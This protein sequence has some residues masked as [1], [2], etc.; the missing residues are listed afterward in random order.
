MAALGT[1]VDARPD[2]TPASPEIVV[3]EPVA[4][5][6]ASGWMRR[7]WEVL[8]LAVAAIVVALAVQHFVYPA[9]SW[10]R[11]EVTYLWQVDGLSAGKVLMTDGGAPQ[12]FWPWLA[13]HTGSAFFAQ[14]T[15]GWPLLLLAVETVFG[16]PL[17]SLAFGT[18]LAVVGTYALARELTGDRSLAL[19][20]GVFMLASPVVVIQSGTY[21]GYLFSLGL[22]L[23]FGTALLAGLRRPSTGLLLLAGV[24]LG[25]LL[26]TRPLDAILWAAP[27]AGYALVV[28]W[29]RWRKLAGATVTLAVGFLPFVAVT[30]LYNRHI[31]GSL[32]TFPLTA[33]DPLDTFGFGI[34]RLMPGA[35]LFSYS[36]RVAIESTLD[37]LPRAA[38]VPVRRFRRCR[39]GR[40]RAVAAPARPQ[41]PRA[42]VPHVRV[43]RRLLRLLG[44]PAVDGV[45]RPVEPRVLHPALLPALRTARDRRPRDVA[46]APRRRGRDVR[47]ARGRHAR[48]AG[49]ADPREPP[50]Q[51]R[52]GTVARRRDTRARAGAR[53]RGERRRLSPPPQSVLA[54]RPGTGRAAPLHGGPR[55][56][57]HR[58]HGPARRPRALPPGHDRPAVGQPDQLPR[59][60]VPHSVTRAAQRAGGQHRR[61]PG[62]ARRTRAAT[63]SSSSTSR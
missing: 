8:A 10:N 62:A 46:P 28:Y 9:F 25:W 40:G 51:R 3:D 29:R 36:G 24:L 16:S 53:V 5:G 2:A 23:L 12:F 45:L 43:P 33:K 60:G 17:L 63:V 15:V 35:A 37:N 20:A 44:Q 19:L 38:A 4:T 26:L 18:V 58:P 34:R 1:D 14:Y 47:G 11:D 61:P 41:H 39:G 56:R 31:S 49:P 21:L 57:R 27:F 59:R 55:S 52:A 48:V 13:G 54:Q 30:L 22:G 42:G 50:H 6:R 32:T 7:N